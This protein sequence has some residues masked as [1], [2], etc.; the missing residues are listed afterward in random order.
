M[1]TEIRFEIMK[2][3]LNLFA[4]LVILFNFDQSF[5]SIPIKEKALFDMGAI[6]GHGSLADYP[7]SNEY[8]YYT[9]PAPYI[10]YRGEL[11]QSGDE[12]GTRFRLLNGESLNFDIS[13]G[14]TFPTDPKK[15]FARRDMPALDWTLEVGPRLLYYLH[16]SKEFGKIRLALPLRSSFSTDFITTKQVGYLFAPSLQIDKNNFPIDNMTL[17]FSASINYLS[18][19]LA[20]YFYEVN[21]AYQTS[22]RAA[23]NAKSGYFG[24]E[25]Y[26]ATKYEHNNKIFLMGL[27]YSDFNGSVNTESYLH[28]TNSSWSY[29]VALGWL[30]FESDQRVGNK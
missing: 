17:Y 27:R 20:D 26:L 2:S 1:A 29:F 13:F 14:G 5:A 19:G 9:L 4:V 18:E 24:W 12:D 16:R 8:R 6:V 15:N 10:S 22:E 21:S 3:R 11:L 28:R 30:L 25:T 7:A 23:Y